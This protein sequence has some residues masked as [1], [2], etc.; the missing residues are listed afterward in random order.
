MWIDFTSSSQ[1]AIKVYA[2][3]VNAVSGEPAVEDTTTI[4]RRRRLVQEGKSIQDYLVT[5]QQKWLDG[6]AIEGGMVR[7]FVA[8]PLGSGYPA[9]VQLTGKDVIG[10]LQFE[11]TPLVGRVL[12]PAT[13]E[14]FV[15][16]LTGF[17]IYIPVHDDYDIEDLKLLVENRKG[18]PKDHQR[19]IFNGKQLEG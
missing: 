7:Q 18:I 16:G 9:E 8:M 19:F 10:G 11:I 3:A 17:S 5:P 6:I 2:G 4:T 12:K 14:I 1:F 13:F 15:K